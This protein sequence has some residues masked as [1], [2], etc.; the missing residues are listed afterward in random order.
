MTTMLSL[1]LHPPFLVATFLP[2]PES[3]KEEIKNPAIFLKQLA[4]FEQ[5]CYS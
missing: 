4:Q 5:K 2:K 3:P 1:I